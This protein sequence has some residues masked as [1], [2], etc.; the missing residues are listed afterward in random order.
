MKILCDSCTTEC[1][2]IKGCPNNL[3]NKYMKPYKELLEDKYGQDSFNDEFLID[4]AS[5]E[6]IH[7]KSLVSYRDRL[8]DIISAVEEFKLD[9]KINPLSVDYELLETILNFIC[10]NTKT[11]F[12]EKS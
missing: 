4:A 9:A 1:L 7:Q 3:F 5:A 12:N 6:S 2:M 8:D 11:I 10:D